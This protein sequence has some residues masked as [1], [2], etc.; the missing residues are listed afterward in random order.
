MANKK[1]VTTK[2]EA[3]KDEELSLESIAKRKAEIDKDERILFQKN[4]M[5]FQQEYAKLCRRYGVSLI[6]T[7]Q[8]S[9]GK[10][11][12]SLTMTEYKH[13]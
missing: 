4:S 9:E 7:C 8:I 11:T 2:K 5:L 6:P 3:V 13:N 1:R 12:Q 10:I